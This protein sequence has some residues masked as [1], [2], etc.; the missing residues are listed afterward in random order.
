MISIFHSC[1]I[2]YKAEQIGNQCENIMFFNFYIK[3]KNKQFESVLG[4][5]SLYTL[6]AVLSNG[7]PNP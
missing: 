5:E 2:V 6:P 3:R 1:F 4:P 7:Q